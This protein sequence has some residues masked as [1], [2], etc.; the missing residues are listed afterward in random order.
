MNGM[1]ITIEAITGNMESGL[2]RLKQYGQTKGPWS[3]LILN[4][5]S[6]N[7]II[8]GLDFQAG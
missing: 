4:T 3:F 8:F 6:T 7:A 5:A 1:I 2:K